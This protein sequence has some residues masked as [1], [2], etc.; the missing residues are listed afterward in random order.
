MRYAGGWKEGRPERAGPKVPHTFG[1]CH[2]DLQRR[3]ATTICNDDLAG[4]RG[5]RAIGTM[6]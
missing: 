5:D 3:F 6:V 2:D 4:Q 1:D